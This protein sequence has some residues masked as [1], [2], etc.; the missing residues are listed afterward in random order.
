MEIYQFE[1]EY[2]RA[3]AAWLLANGVNDPKVQRQDDIKL[4]DGSKRTLTTPRVEVKFMC[5]G[6]TRE[7]YHVV[8]QTGATWLD[9]ADGVLYLKIVT[10]RDVK[11]PSHSYLRGLCRYAMQFASSISGKMKYHKIEKVLESSST[12][13][14]EADKNHDVSALSFNTTLRIRPEFFPTS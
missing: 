11:E 9:F 12:S 7:H 8:T 2:E 6:L 3:V 13:T 14:M 10:R 1:D 4:E 5:S